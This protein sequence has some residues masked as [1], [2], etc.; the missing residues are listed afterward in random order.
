MK[1][2]KYI[3]FV[4]LAS[5]LTVSC[6]DGIDGDDG[7]GSEIITEYVNVSSTDWEKIGVKMN[8]SYYVPKITQKIV[9]SGSV[10]VYKQEGTMWELLPYKKPYNSDD[11][12]YCYSFKK[13]E[14]SLDCYAEKILPKKDWKIK[15]VI[16]PGK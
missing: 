13:G 15:I 9:D 6:K 4:I 2:V 11:E 1:I 14:L 5:L 16:I 10:L 8:I 3:V 7:V 12:L